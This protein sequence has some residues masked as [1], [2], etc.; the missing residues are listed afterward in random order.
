MTDRDDCILEHLAE[1][2]RVIRLHEQDNEQIAGRGHE[3]E[4]LEFAISNLAH[5]YFAG[6]DSID[7]HRLLDELLYGLK[8]A[9]RYDE[10]RSVA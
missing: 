10:W 1:L 9:W 5:G 4:P 3:P 7:T 2:V 8:P 6:W